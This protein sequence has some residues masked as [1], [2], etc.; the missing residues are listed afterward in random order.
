MDTVEVRGVSDV[1]VEL[2]ICGISKHTASVET[3]ARSRVLSQAL[4]AA[5]EDGVE[6]GT[7]LVPGG[8]LTAWLSH[9]LNS[10]Q[11]TAREEVDFDAQELLTLLK[12]GH[13]CLCDSCTTELLP[14]LAAS[15]HQEQPSV[16]HRKYA[17]Y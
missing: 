7:M 1:L 8:Y 2:V 14:Q 13:H 16:L 5:A 3:L 6:V 17:T 15:L 12:V 11:A 9:V 4:S 10:N